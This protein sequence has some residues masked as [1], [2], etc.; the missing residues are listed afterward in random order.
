M[1]LGLWWWQC[2]VRY[3]LLLAPPPGISVVAIILWKNWALNKSKERTNLFRTNLCSQTTGDDKVR[4]TSPPHSPNL[5]LL[6]T[7]TNKQTKQNKNKKGEREGKKYHMPV[8]LSS[9]QRLYLE[10]GRRKDASNIRFPL[11]PA[12]FSLKTKQNNTICL[13][14]SLVTTLFS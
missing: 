8:M 14:W 10:H 13:W 11:L 7:K 2:G 3:N 12:S 1:V 9:D 6:E 4:A 5:L